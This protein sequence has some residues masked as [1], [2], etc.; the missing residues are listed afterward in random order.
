MPT[1]TVDQPTLEKLERLASERGVT[2][3]EWLA[4]AVETVGPTGKEAEREPPPVHNQ[5][6]TRRAESI[7]DWL[8]RIAARHKGVSGFVDD[9][10]DSIYEPPRGL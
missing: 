7:E 6:A 10:R 5:I 4:G 3:G 1:L 9:S 8:H 2:V